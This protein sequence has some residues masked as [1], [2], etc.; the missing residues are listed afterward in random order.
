MNREE[1][2]ELAHRTVWE[3]INELAGHRAYAAIK[4]DEEE[5]PCITAVVNRSDAHVIHPIGKDE[6]H[7]Q[8]NA[9][10]EK[11]HG[12][13]KSRIDR[14][15]ERGRTESRTYWL[16]VYERSSDEL[17]YAPVEHL[18]QDRTI[19]NI[20]TDKK[21]LGGERMYY[22]PRAAFDTIGADIV[23]EDPFDDGAGPATESGQS[24]LGNWC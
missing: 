11:Q 17:C 10:F 12:Y 9:G 18:I 1:L 15:V 16:F 21:A 8:R 22:W 6:P 4:R 19:A 23:D 13:S 20:V 24:G 14:L 3:S 7:V 5:I 2:N